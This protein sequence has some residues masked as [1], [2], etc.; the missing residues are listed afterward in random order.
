MA[1]AASDSCEG[2]AE[3][4]KH[5]L[6]AVCSSDSGVGSSPH[7]LETPTSNSAVD[8]QVPQYIYNLHQNVGTLCK[9]KKY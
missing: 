7:T 3:K 9:I 2:A 4:I 6:Q 1:E 5:S 8:V